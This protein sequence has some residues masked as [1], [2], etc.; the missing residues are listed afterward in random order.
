MKVTLGN[1]E[2]TVQFGFKPTLQSGLIA[3]VVKMENLDESDI[4]SIQEILLMTPKVLLVGL[5]THHSDEFGYDCKT[6][7]G[8]D[9]QYDKVF[10]ILSEN[11]DSGDINCIDL[12]GDLISELEENSFLSQM[13]E[14]E[15]KTQ[16]PAK[17]AT[18]KKT[19]SK[20]N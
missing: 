1:K 14:K 4:N 9:D 16:T 8:Y 11:V 20:Q 18:P 12:L 15:R 17:K 2:Y 6:K 10:S 3:D 7:E 13:M 19:T 5:Q